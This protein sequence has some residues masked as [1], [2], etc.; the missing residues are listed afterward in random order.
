MRVFTDTVVA[1]A[2]GITYGKPWVTDTYASPFAVGIGVKIVGAAS[3][4]YTVQHTFDDP[5]AVD[6]AA[7]PTNATWYNNA[8][9]VS[10]TTNQDGNYAFPVRAIRI[11]IASA[12]SAQATMTIV[13]AGPTI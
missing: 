9:L 2:G 10:A 12:A 11:I 6:I 8:T 1:S 7:L 3:A 5:F 4:I 13:Q